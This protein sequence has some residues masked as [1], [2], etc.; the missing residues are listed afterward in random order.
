MI[1]MPF[2]VCVFICVDVC[3]C[4]SVVV[5]LCAFVSR[6]CGVCERGVVVVF[7][8]DGVRNCVV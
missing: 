5:L 4:V 7:W 6:H 1:S 3:L 2:M 8:C